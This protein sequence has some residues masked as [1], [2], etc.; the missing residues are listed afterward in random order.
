MKIEISDELFEKMKTFIYSNDPINNCH[1]TSC[2][3]CSRCADHE[4][5]HDWVEAIPIVKTTPKEEAEKCDAEDCPDYEDGKCST[6]P[7]SNCP[8]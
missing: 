2:E 8:S 4:Q 5:L 6:Y 3:G 7:T 1:T